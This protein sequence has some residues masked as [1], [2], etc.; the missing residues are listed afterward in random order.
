MWKKL[1]KFI[2]KLF[3][4]T[5]TAEDIPAHERFKH[6]RDN[7]L[8]RLL[9]IA[10]IAEIESVKQVP[11]RGRRVQHPL[12]QAAF[13]V[14]YK[15]CPDI[16]LK[17]TF[18]I[19]HTDDVKPDDGIGTYR[20]M[21]EECSVFILGTEDFAA[22]VIN[23]VAYVAHSEFGLSDSPLYLHVTHEYQHL[24]ID[25]ALSTEARRIALMEQVIFALNKDP[26]TK[27]KSHA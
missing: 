18:S 3:P 7:K 26:N 2:R 4:Q 16:R 20:G 10:E 19:Y 11:T 12:E 8:Y 24:V 6:Y 23:D 13:I 21:I 14:T 25:N 17:I 9:S 15:K 22:S 5:L 1:E 27:L